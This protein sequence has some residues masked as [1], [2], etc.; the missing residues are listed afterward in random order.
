MSNAT[1]GGVNAQKIFLAN[2]GVLP[3]LFSLL[4]YCRENTPQSDLR[5]AAVILEGV[6]NLLNAGVHEFEN[7]PVIRLVTH[8]HGFDEIKMWKKHVQYE[9]G[10]VAGYIMR[11]LD[12]FCPGHEQGEEEEEANLVDVMQNINH[13]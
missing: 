12:N 10:G 8:C 1:S 4:R 9:V 13:G 2:L 3:P 5:I 11:I 6:F 7:N